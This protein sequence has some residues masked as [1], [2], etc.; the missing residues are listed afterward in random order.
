MNR[1][2][3]LAIVTTHPIQYNAPLF[4][5]MSEEGNNFTI[6][7]FYTWGQSKERVYDKDFA[8]II[9]WDI[10]LLEDYESTFV[11]NTSTKPGSHHFNGIV[12][13]TLNSEIEEWKADSILI[14]GW[15]FSSHLKAIRYF[16]KKVPVVFRGD[17]TMLDE[18]SGYSVKKIL[19]RLL[20]KKIYSRVD[21]VLY[22]GSAN[23][24]Y[25][26][27]HGLKPQQL[28]FGP[29][30][31]DNERFFDKDGSYTAKANAWRNDLGIAEQDTVF[32]FAGKL[33]EKKDPELLIKSFLALNRPESWLVLVGNGEL[34]VELK[35]TYSSHPSILFIDFQ[36]QSVMPV[37][38][39]LA[40]VFVLPSK[41]PNETWG[42]A[43]NE[44][45][46]CGRAVI[47]SDKCGCSQDLILNGRNGYVF[48]SGSSNSLRNSL[49]LAIEEFEK[50]GEQSQEII[51]EWSYSKTIDQL[52]I[53]LEKSNLINE[54]SRC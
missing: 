45:M 1:K 33:S 53:L 34:E 8:Q 11:T 52:N 9:S 18:P 12:N 28:M 21:Y 13:P 48:N 46:A 39:R 54:K 35:K 23:K 30:A 31:V 10:P 24:K 17:S 14:Y 36:N 47:A 27:K 5:L 50:M 38:Y 3:R 22:V 20:L 19:R 42:L 15:A 6:K 43:V 41:G 26:L 37:V 2:T 32:L 44:A 51:K 29:H 25:F 7:V 4:K 40:N 49:R 16:Y